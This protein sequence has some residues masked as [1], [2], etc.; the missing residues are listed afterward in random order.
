MS[1]V[2]IHDHHDRPVNKKTEQGARFHAEVSRFSKYQVGYL[3]KIG[4][5][6][7]LFTVT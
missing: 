5:C 6:G 4:A 3:K 1:F 2:L 7:G